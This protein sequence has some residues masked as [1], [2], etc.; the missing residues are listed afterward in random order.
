M[1]YID[2]DNL[3]DIYLFESRYCSKG[4]TILST[5]QLYEMPKNIA[6]YLASHLFYSTQSDLLPNCQI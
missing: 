3:N 6:G 5:D 2:N 4:K 1:Q